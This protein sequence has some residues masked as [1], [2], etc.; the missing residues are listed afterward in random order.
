MRN[1]HY[2]L[3]LLQIKIE[4]SEWETSDNGTP[5]DASDDCTDFSTSFSINIYLIPVIEIDEDATTA[6]GEVVL[7]TTEDYISYSWSNSE[8][9]VTTTV[10]EG[11]YT[12]T[13]ETDNGCMLTSLPFEV[14]ASL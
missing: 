10:G 9:G 5:A 4:L 7:K 1:Y 3:Y 14:L 8:N 13:V 6:D 2:C 11:S 12:V